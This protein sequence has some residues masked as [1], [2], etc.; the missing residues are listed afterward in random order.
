MV[1]LLKFPLTVTVVDS[2]GHRLFTVA[3]G[4][5]PQRHTSNWHLVSYNSAFI[6]WVK[7]SRSSKSPEDLH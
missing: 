3:E 7:R 4:H 2:T 5:T 1:I 6:H